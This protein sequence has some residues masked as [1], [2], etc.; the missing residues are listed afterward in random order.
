MFQKQSNAMEYKKT[1]AAQPDVKEDEGKEE[2]KN[3][4]DEEEEEE[5]LGEWC[6][7]ICPK[8]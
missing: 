6:L 3:K 4:G 8:S 7:E 2:E 5:K 1:D